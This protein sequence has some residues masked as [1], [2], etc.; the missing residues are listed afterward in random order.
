MRIFLSDL[1]LDQPATPSFA[2]F[3]RVLEQ[4]AERASAIYILGDLCEVWVGDDDDGPL[5][6]ALREVLRAASRRCPIFLMHGN[7][8]FLIG[9]RF[10][11]ETGCQ[12]LEDTTLLEDGT[13]LSHGDGFCIDDVAYQQARQT[14]RSSEWQQGILSMTLEQR[15]VLAGAMRAE[16]Q[17]TSANK[18]A[19]IMD[20]SSIEVSRI[21][22]ETGADR[23]VHGHTHRPGVHVSDWGARYVL[24]AWERCGW[25]LRMLPGQSPRLECFPLDR[26]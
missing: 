1:H 19:N 8:D 20:V 23:L 13:L 16:S 9:P 7:R 11:Q 17:R 2:T 18:A 4:E 6:C 12:L 14:L 3:A 5:A 10:A 21:V 24:G 15:R 26:I 22:R 25:L